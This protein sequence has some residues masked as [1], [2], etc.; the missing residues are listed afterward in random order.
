MIRQ[1]CITADC[2]SHIAKT[3]QNDRSSAAATAP[4]PASP[5]DSSP[6]P[7]PG[8][9][10][11]PVRSTILRAFQLATG[12]A[13][14]NLVPDLGVAPNLYASGQRRGG[15]QQLLQQLPHHPSVQGL[16]DRA[17]ITNRERIVDSQVIVDES[18]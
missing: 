11:V 18:A 12:R 13:G 8:P 6:L 15:A 4:T 17:D 5:L 1:E 14:E 7:T 2:A 16:P 10:V 9:D 3:E